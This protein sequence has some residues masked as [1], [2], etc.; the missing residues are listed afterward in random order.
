MAA[1]LPCSHV[2]FPLGLSG[3][4]EGGRER[5]EKRENS[6]ISS[7]KDTNRIGS[8]SPYDSSFFFFNF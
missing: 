8:G 1:F 4:R 6:D 2:A 5:E 3:G 7:Q